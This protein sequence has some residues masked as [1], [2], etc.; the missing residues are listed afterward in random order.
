L[1][2]HSRQTGSWST[3]LGTG[4]REESASKA[5]ARFNLSDLPAR[6][7]AD[8]S[9][10]FRPLTLE[11]ASSSLVAPARNRRVPTRQRLLRR[12]LCLASTT[13]T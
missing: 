3:S 9:V 8:L 4:A 1:K 12:L 10:K 7:S 2:L 11:V 13:W 6:S 5:K